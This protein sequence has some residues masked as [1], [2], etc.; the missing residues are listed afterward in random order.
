M[1]DEFAEIVAG[2]EEEFEDG[3]P[4]NYAVL[5]NVDLMRQYNALKNDLL[6]RGVLL[7]PSEPED[8]DK[9]AQYYGMRQE[10]IK[11]GMA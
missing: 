1:D 7:H 10:L 2:M 5:S 4:K 11:R 9:Q 8:I 6:D 3:V